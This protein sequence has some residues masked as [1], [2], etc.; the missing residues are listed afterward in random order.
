MADGGHVDLIIKNPCL[1]D[2]EYRTSISLAASVRELKEVLQQSHPCRPRV[3]EQKI[4][5]AGKVLAD[6]DGL[7]GH[8]ARHDTS[9]PI[10]LHLVIRQAHNWPSQPAQPQAE[11]SRTQAQSPVDAPPTADVDAP[12]STA[13]S[14]GLHAEAGQWVYRCVGQQYVTWE[15]HGQ[16]Y[17]FA[18]P[19]VQPFWEAASGTG[20]SFAAWGHQPAMAASAWGGGYPA[21]WNCGFYTQ[22]PWPCDGAGLY[23]PHGAHGQWQGPGLAGD[24]G[25]APGDAADPAQDARDPAVAHEPPAPAQ[26]DEAAGEAVVPQREALQLALKLVLLVFMLGQD[27]NVQR[28]V[29]LSLVAVVIFLFQTNTF[30]A[31]VPA[32][33]PPPP[34]QGPPRRVGDRDAGVPEAPAA[35]APM[36]PAQPSLL[37]DAV[38]LLIAFFSSL[39]PGWQLQQHI[40]P[41]DVAYG[42]PPDGAM[43][44]VAGADVGAADAAAQAAPMDR[45]GIN[46][47]E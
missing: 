6:C 24:A 7:D 12:P 2:A 29:L 19:L 27:G 46:A 36:P 39:F 30:P 15:I 13:E 35:E 18:Q 26:D 11:Q 25:G 45:D 8:M 3:D 41:A 16:P 1:P 28:I 40:P 5:F 43:P 34:A 33:R 44:A 17:V 9:S 23:G 38:S 37:G 31:W 20:T 47:N 22:Q 4:I 32:L 42:A 21:V 14:S 10:T